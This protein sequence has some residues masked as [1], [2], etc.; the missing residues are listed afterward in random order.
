MAVGAGK[1]AKKVVSL[2]AHAEAN[3]AFRGSG[4]VVG[5]VP[6]DELR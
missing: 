6:V 2:L 4:A 3:I 5:F 1:G